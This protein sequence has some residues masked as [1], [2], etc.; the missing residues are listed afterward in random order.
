MADNAD[1]I[2]NVRSQVKIL[3]DEKRDV[4][5]TLLSVSSDRDELE[6]KC[7]L[8][9]EE[10]RELHEK[11]ESAVGM[12]VAFVDK[13]EK[14]K[15]DV[16]A[17]TTKRDA[18]EQLAKEYHIENEANIA[19]CAQLEQTIASLQQEREVLEKESKAAIVK[20]NE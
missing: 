6:E 9:D 13:A 2:A 20:A 12:G 19:K 8:A 14:Y 4:E 15:K 3:E 11:L 5:D 7:E 1:T 16:A 17:L 18:A 10:L